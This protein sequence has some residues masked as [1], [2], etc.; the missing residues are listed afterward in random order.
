MLIST[1]AHFLNLMKI[2]VILLIVL[3]FATYVWRTPVKNPKLLTERVCNVIKLDVKMR[4]MSLVLK[5]PVYYV[6]R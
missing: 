4:F 1:T 2:F 5:P 3:R 6:K